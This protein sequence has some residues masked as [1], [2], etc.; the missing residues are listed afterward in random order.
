MK[1]I[2]RL[3][4]FCLCVGIILSITS[5]AQQEYFIF[6][7]NN[8][9][10][11]FYARIS[12]KVYSASGIGHLV[13]PALKDSTYTISIGFPKNQFPELD[14]VIS[15]NKKDHGYELKSMGEQGWLLF[16]VSNLQLVKPKLK[17]VA[18]ISAG[19][20]KKK[21]D[22]YS[23][24][25]AAIVNDT[26]VLYTTVASYSTEPPLALN[27]V[28]RD[29]R[30]NT[31]AQKAIELNS[32]TAL[33]KNVRNQPQ[34]DVSSK[35]TDTLLAKTSPVLSKKIDTTIEIRSKTE[36]V[37]EPV[38]RNIPTPSKIKDTTSV[39]GERISP[40]ISLK[41][42]ILKIR[43]ESKPSFLALIFVINDSFVIDTVDVV[44]P[45]D[46]SEITDLNKRDSPITIKTAPPVTQV[47][48]ITSDST[49][50]QPKISMI[51]SDC[52]NFASEHDV[53]KLRIKILA[54]KKDQEKIA[55]ARKFYKNKCFTARQIRAL[56][57][58]FY[59][60][61]GKYEFLAASYPFIS[62]SENYRKLENLLSDRLYVEKFRSLFNN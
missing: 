21:T 27:P 47:P 9:A 15:V 8:N 18:V 1:R 42:N 53:D 62:D 55:A 24:L 10:Q 45:F 30:G 52:R 26:T 48:P 29:H 35:L 22:S 4:C 38:F 41:S 7:Q 16:N 11:Q 20:I 14:F 51:N 40:V 50:S 6:I 33:T 31:S 23:V 43:E 28:S 5:I 39:K 36:S 60:E 2:T 12:E 37:E 44:I 46:P 25:M 49:L 59:I 19:D 54:E 17:S 13:I 61:G 58:L 3:H 32:D 34:K 57:E 56:S